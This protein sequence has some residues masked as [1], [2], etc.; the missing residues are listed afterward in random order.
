MRW[1][2][3][4]LAMLREM[5]IRVWAPEAAAAPEEEG[6][7]TM[8]AERVPA[9]AGPAAVP[10]ARAPAAAYE[11]GGSRP[12]A[13]SQG[14]ATLAGPIASE[15][16]LSAEWLVLGEPF[17][18]TAADPAAAAEQEL[19]LDNMLRAIRVSRRSE[20]REG[21][22]CHL[23]VEEARAGEIAA[24]IEAVRP[25]CILALGR[26]AALA[27]LGVDEPLG[28][29]RERLHQRDGIPVV[30]TFAL[31]YLLRHAADKPRAWADLCRAVA[32]IA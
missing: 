17:A 8:V 28:K 21:R 31:P 14:A 20:V 2:E 11:R 24:A 15:A 27:L 18:S 29:L 23:P 25:R 10:V 4:Q 3:R 22:A 6:A 1:S 30:V 19:L 13:P 26:A 5:G 12:V 16:L 7:A 32:A 9:A